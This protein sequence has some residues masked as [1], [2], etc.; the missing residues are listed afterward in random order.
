LTLDDWTNASL[1]TKRLAEDIANHIDNEEGDHQSTD[2]HR[3][4]M[5]SVRDNWPTTEAQR[6]AL[7]AS[8][9]KT[10][11]HE[12]ERIKVLEA[13]LAAKTIDK[14]PLLV[15]TGINMNQMTIIRKHLGKLLETTMKGVHVIGLA[16]GSDLNGLND[17]QLERLGLQRKAKT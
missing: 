10:F 5:T 1:A 12:A 11:E 8:L 4:I 3:L 9:L 16:P 6:E 2:L 7:E 13:A 15:F 17:A 14:A